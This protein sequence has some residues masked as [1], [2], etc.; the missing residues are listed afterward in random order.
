MDLTYVC[1]NVR[2]TRKVLR[3]HILAVYLTIK[4]S[5]TVYMIKRDDTHTCCTLISNEQTCLITTSIMSQSGDIAPK[6]KL[7]NINRTE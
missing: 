4:M 7:E 6:A 2:I 5:L 1:Q 3:K